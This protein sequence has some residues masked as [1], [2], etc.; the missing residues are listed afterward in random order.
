MAI[1]IG[2][3]S[4]S[5]PDG[6]PLKNDPVEIA[7]KMAEKGITLYCAGCEPSLNPY[8]QVFTAVCLVTGGKYVSLDDAKKLTNVIIGGT[9]EEISIEKAKAKIHNDIM[10]EETE[11]E[12]ESMKKN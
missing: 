2:I 6:C 12:K 4:D 9:R 10:R 3:G 5:M 7:H 8:R 11:K 1:L